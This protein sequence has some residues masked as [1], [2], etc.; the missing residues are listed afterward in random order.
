MTFQGPGAD[1]GAQSRQVVSALSGVDHLVYA[2]PELQAGI[3]RIEGLLGIRAVDGGQH[4]GGGTRN[5][6]LALGPTSYLELIGPD[7]EQDSFSG[8]RLFGID[9]LTAPRLVTWA[10]RGDDLDRLAGLD[11]GG[12]V[13][14]GPVGAGSRQT[15]RGVHL[16]WRL[17]NPRSVVADGVVPF[18]IN[19]GDTPHPARTATPGAA[20]VDLRAEHPDPEQV[21]GMLSK[22][23][24]ALPVSSGP[25]AALVAVIVSPRGRVAL[26]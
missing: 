23:G 18:F 2:T 5:A 21:R 13:R 10:A 15:P 17:T 7:P 9:S 3:D 16:S 26:R 8:T 25:R 4:P 14:L 19:W 22:L 12:G 6:L 20:L 24:L 11:L 1:S